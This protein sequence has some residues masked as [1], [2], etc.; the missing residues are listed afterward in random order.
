MSLFQRWLRPVCVCLALLSSP[1]LAAA[2]S[3]TVATTVTWDGSGDAIGYTVKWGT[4]LGDYPNRTD[5][6]TTVHT[7]TDLVASRAYYAVVEAYAADG[8]RS[9]PSQ[10]LRFITDGPRRDLDADG[11]ADI[12]WQ[13]IKT[14]TVAAW[15]MSAERMKESLLTS[16]AGVS[17]TAWRIAGSGDFNGDSKPDLVWQNRTHG[18][19]AVWL[20]NGLQLIDSASLSPGQVSDTSWEI[21]TVADLNGDGKSDLVWQ[22]RSAGWIAVWLMNGTQLL[23]SIGVKPEQISDT[24]WRIVGAGDMNGDG[25]EDL[26]WRHVKDGYLAAWLMDG[27]TLLD[28]ALLTPDR[29]TDV[30]WSLVGVA[31]ADADGQ[32]DLYWRDNKNGHLAVWLMKG[33]KLSKSIA[34]KPERVDD[35]NWRIVAVR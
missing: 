25:K 7:F 8:R 12:V 23:E 16:P 27:T 35:P 29:V 20:M 28:S 18:W 34:L 22:D 32:S 4:A 26:I 21:S 30:N 15:T 11:Q 31:D 1:S 24:A 17:D 6:A 10:P 2:Q 9:A 13:N 3:T 33:L 19:L 14:G 5:V